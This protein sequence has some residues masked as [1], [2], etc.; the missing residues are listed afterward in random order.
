MGLLGSIFGGVASL[1]GAGVNANAQDKANETNLKIAQMNNEFNERMLQKQM[2]Y[3]TEM[4]NAQNE[5]NSAS[6]QR[7]RL[8]AAGLNPYM[9]MSG[10][11]A[12]TAQSASGIN[13]PTAQQV[14]VQPVQY[15]MST[16]AGFLSQA[17]D[18][19]S[20]QSQRDADAALKMRQ[21]EG[22][23]IEN[24]YKAQQLTAQINKDISESKNLDE[25][26]RYQ[27]IWNSF[28]PSLFQSD[29][30]V[31]QQ[32][33][34]NLEMDSLFKLAQT[35]LSLIQGRLTQKQL[36]SFDTRFWAEL[37]MMS[38]Q[39]A[40]A[41]SSGHASEAQ[42]EA[43]LANAME[44]KARAAGI[45]I[46]NG[47]KYK[48]AKTLVDTAKQ[49]LETEKQNTKIAENEA[50]NYW[51]NKALGLFTGFGTAAAGFALGRLGLKKALPIKGF[52]R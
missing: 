34:N 1:V 21:A 5:Y 15:D 12:G 24:Q 20:V 51:V 48:T 11:S 33:A 4:W 49:T 37:S 46:D 7:A 38:A 52:G 41:I 22:I 8:E 29:M 40:A 2:D 17:I 43:A 50:D 14:Q 25:K 10:G 39:Q 31:K 30:L 32:T 9:M 3:N 44:S 19:A 42:A 23:H 27:Q 45:R 28:A 35:N 36:D 6:N 18:L 47:V 16:A 13:P 26:T